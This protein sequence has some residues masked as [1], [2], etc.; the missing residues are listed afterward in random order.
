[1]IQLLVLIKFSDVNFH[2]QLAE[3]RFP[4]FIVC[5]MVLTELLP[6]G[7]ATDPNRGRTQRDPVICK[8]RVNIVPPIIYSM[9]ILGLTQ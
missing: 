4:V 1:M 3:L 5:C 7:R 9:T 2:R 6:R 8:V